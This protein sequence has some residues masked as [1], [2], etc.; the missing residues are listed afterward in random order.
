MPLSLHSK[1]PLSASDHRRVFPLVIGHLRIADAK[2][3]A[4]RQRS[5]VS[6]PR[7]RKVFCKSEVSVADSLYLSVSVCDIDLNLCDSPK[8]DGNLEVILLL[9]ALLRQKT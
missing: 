8:G 5:A 7:S 4:S 3:V 2:Y 9:S 1:L 6:F